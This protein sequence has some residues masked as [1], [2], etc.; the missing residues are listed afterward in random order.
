MKNP[1]D[2]TYY[3]IHKT[4]FDCVIIKEQ[5]MKEDG[6]WDEYHRK[7]KNEEI[8][9]KI[10]DFKIWV[11]EKLK[12]KNTFVTEQGDVERWI[13][14]IDT[15]KEDENVKSVIDYLEALKT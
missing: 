15:D 10:R 7:I 2:K 9:N 5:K 1:N 11:K 8:D 4:C 6:T 12:E 3:K 14:K 13:E